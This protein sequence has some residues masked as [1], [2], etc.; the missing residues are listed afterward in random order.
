MKLS[1]KINLL[2]T[3]IVS[4]ILF[5]VAL[6]VYEVS[7]KDVNTDFQHRLNTRAARTAYLYNVF[8][9]DTT[10]LLKKLDATTP[11]VLFNKN[12]AIY[13]D[14]RSLLYEYHDDSSYRMYPAPA[15]FDEAR[16]NGEAYFRDG[17]KDVC[18]LYDTS[19]LHR[20]TIMVA[21]ENVAGEA[22][23][24]DLKRVFLLFYPGAVLVTLLA[25]YLFSRSI[26]RP[27]KGTIQDVRLITS[28]NLSQRLYVGGRKDELSELNSTFNDLLDRLEEAFALQRRFISNA[29]HEL[30]TPLTSVSSQIEVALLQARTPQEYQAILRSVLEDVQQLNHLTRT[31]LEITKTGSHGAI[32]L[33]NLRVDEILMKAMGDVVRQNPGYHVIPDFDELPDEE[34]ECQVFG[35]SH[36]LYIAF[37]N[38]LDNGCKYSPDKTVQVQL[39]FDHEAVI[40]DFYNKS[41]PITDVELEKLFEPFYR[42]QN[43]SG[44]PGAGLGLTLTRRIIGLHKGSLEMTSDATNGTRLHLTLPVLQ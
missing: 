5:A 30:S 10:N 2:F 19:G 41:E 25:G 4:G 16:E 39:H 8:H 23:I 40:L 34:K 44:L 28:Q 6:L 13:D 7:K 27:V 9:N 32:A 43:A 18:M 21:A 15:W 3:I 29:S 38:I 22:Y 37:R 36:L 31:L 17:N 11:P 35:N 1:Y 24:R 33:E 20:F 42:S 14:N 26:I 12:I